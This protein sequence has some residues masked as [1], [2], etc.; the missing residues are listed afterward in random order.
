MRMHTTVQQV[1]LFKDLYHSRYFKLNPPVSCMDTH[2]LKRPL[3]TMTLSKNQLTVKTIF[4]L[5]YK[6][7]S[8]LS[9]GGAC[10]VFNTWQRLH[11]GQASHFKVVVIFHTCSHGKVRI[12]AKVCQVKPI[13]LRISWAYTQHIHDLQTSLY[14]PVDICWV[15]ENKT[16][17]QTF[18]KNSQRV[19]NLT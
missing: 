14:S 5:T 12:P 6:V 4:L 10:S 16:Y 11:K 18:L 9:W 1:S 13:M 7:T 3:H 19:S 17:S 15:V 2:S 8:F